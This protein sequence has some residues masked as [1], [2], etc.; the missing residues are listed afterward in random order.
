MARGDSQRAI[1]AVTKLLRD[2]LS[3][4]GFNIGVGR[5]EEALTSSSAAKLNLF[6]YELSFDGPMRNVALEEGKPPPV[7]AASPTPTTTSARPTA[8]T[9]LRRRTPSARH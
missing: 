1:G 2:H 6:L 7:W 8:A 4:Q 3:R 5:P 9:A